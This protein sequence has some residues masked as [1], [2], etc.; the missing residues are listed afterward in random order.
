MK[1]LVTFAATA[2]V[3]FSASALAKAAPG[4]VNPDFGK[5]G[6]VRVSTRPVWDNCKS[7]L[8]VMLSE[9]LQYFSFKFSITSYIVII[10]PKGHGNAAILVPCRSAGK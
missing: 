7:A 1:A 10:E 4:S 6:F 2:A 9:S 8:H 3:L 5:N